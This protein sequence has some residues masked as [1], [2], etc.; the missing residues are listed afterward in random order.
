MLLMGIK[1]KIFQI[2]RETHPSVVKAAVVAFNT[3]LFRETGW[4]AFCIDC[5]CFAHVA[6]ACTERIASPIDCIKYA[7]DPT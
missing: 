3:L 6:Y 1:K 4:A 2:I 7:T 5:T